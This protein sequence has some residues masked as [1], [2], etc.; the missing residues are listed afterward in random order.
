MLHCINYIL[1]FIVFYQKA[2]TGCFFTDGTVSE[3]VADG[4]ASSIAEVELAHCL[5]IH[6]QLGL[7]A[8]TVHP[9]LRHQCVRKM[10]TV[11][12]LCNMD[13][14][15]SQLFQHPVIESV[16][17][18][19]RIIPP[20]NSGLVGNYD[21]QEPCLLQQPHPFHSAGQKFK[22]FNPVQIVFF[23][24]DCSIPVQENSLTLFFHS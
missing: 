3:L 2:I 13:T 14:L 6:T 17:I 15:S 24:I 21:Q 1:F 22:V 7:A 11:I 18:S 23:H 19:L 9:V 5:F 12:Y 16:K 8:I 10:R 20:G 4:I